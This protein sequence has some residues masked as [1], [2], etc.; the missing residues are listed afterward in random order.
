MLLYGFVLALQFTNYFTNS[1]VNVML[2]ELMSGNGFWDISADQLTNMSNQ[3]AT[4]A[5]L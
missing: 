1:E 5:G 3:I 4:A 2:D